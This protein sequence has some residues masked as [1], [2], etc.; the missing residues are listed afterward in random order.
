MSKTDWASRLNLYD[1]TS[2]LGA[3]R[4]KVRIDKDK[5]GLSKNFNPI[6][7]KKQWEK[8]VIGVVDTL[9]EYNN[10]FDKLIKEYK[11]EDKMSKF[12]K[13]LDK[14]SVNID[15]NC[16]IC[17]ETLSS[18]DVIMLPDCKHIIHK[19]CIKKTFL[20]NSNK[21]E[22]PLCRTSY[23]STFS[24]LTN[25]GNN[26]NNSNSNGNSSNIDDGNNDNRYCDRC[27]R[28]LNPFNS[29]ERTTCVHCLY[30]NSNEINNG[31]N[32]IIIRHCTDCGRSLLNNLYNGLCVYC[33]YR[34]EETDDEEESEDDSES[35][36]DPDN[37][38]DGIHT[39]YNCGDCEF[40]YGNK[41]GRC[42]TIDRDR[43]ENCSRRLDNQNNCNRCDN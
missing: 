8:V 9:K 7:L 17:L 23:S 18:K 19:E 10:Q 31:S 27:E 43:C 25:N 15:D 26:S 39:C 28:R 16:S 4:I 37:D 3:F 42:N 2:S 38:P 22:C 14:F 24:I 33:Y 41:C 32:D 11:E 40:F 6:E 1:I 30:G 12:N 36:G 21:I 29:F 13:E 5:D 35:E 34:E 20:M